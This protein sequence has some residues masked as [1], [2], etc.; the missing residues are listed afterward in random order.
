M[1]ELGVLGKIGAHTLDRVAALKKTRPVASLKDS[2]LYARQPLSLDAALHGD[3]PRII[4]EVKFH[5]PSEGILRPGASPKAAAEIAH[6]YART[7]AAA[8]SILTEPEYFHGDPSFLAAARAELPNTPLLMKDF[9]VDPY[10]FELARS[11]GADAVLL[12]VALLGPNL[13]AMLNSA[14]SLGLSV[15]I[16]AHDEAEAA[17]A[18][19]AGDAV[20]GVNNRDLK[21]LKV[22]LAVSKRIAPLLNGRTAVSESGLRSRADIDALAALGYKGFL[23]GTSFMKSPYPAVALKTFLS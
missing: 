15:L 6:A 9:M 23:V 3:G 17:A 22:D 5:S 12:I 10:Q 18:L 7:G 8:I 20:I 19:A 13:S 16:E 14:R 11:I 21:S 4:A 1:G 2:P